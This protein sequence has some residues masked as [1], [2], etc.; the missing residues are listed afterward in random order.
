MA[1]VIYLQI[2]GPMVF[3]VLPF[4]NFLY[5][6]HLYKNQNKL[7]LDHMA[8]VVNILFYSLIRQATY[9]C[10]LYRV[11]MLLM[12]ITHNDKSVMSGQAG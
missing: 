5:N 1:K 9:H 11:I 3:L 12:Y 8:Q 2:Q 7:H 6:H 10:N 4:C